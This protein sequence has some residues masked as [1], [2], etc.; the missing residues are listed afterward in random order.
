MLPSTCKA[1]LWGQGAVYGGAIKWQVGNSICPSFHAC[2]PHWLACIYVLKKNTNIL[3]NWA[4]HFVFK[5]D[6]VR[7]IRLA[8]HTDI[9]T[10]AAAD[11]PPP[12]PPPAADA[13]GGGKSLLTVND[14]HILSIFL[15][16]ATAPALTT[17]FPSSY[18]SEHT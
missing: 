13:G 16:E 1:V 4:I 10:S 9:F 18:A 8:A 11:P 15:E 12:P 7:E 5:R 2:L 14:I 17:P 6:R 3:F